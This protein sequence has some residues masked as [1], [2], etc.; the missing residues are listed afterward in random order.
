LLVID[1]IQVHAA[2][3]RLCG[4]NSLEG[5]MLDTGASAADF[6][7]AIMHVVHEST[8]RLGT[9]EDHFEEGLTAAA[10]TVGLCCWHASADAFT[11]YRFL[12]YV[13]VW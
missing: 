6:A 9:S 5:F 7:C 1:L 8:S 11:V 13:S 10:T 12:Y 2:F 3:N 4:A